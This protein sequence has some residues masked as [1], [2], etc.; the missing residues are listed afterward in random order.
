M[1]EPFMATKIDGRVKAQL[2]TEA[3][4]RASA[5]AAVLGRTSAFT[6]LKVPAV[7]DMEAV[8]AATTLPT[9]LL[10]GEVRKDQDAYFESWRTALAVPNLVGVVVGRSQLYPSDDDVALAV[11]TAVGLFPSAPVLS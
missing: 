10:G 8:A 2:R 9:L 4:V 3:A 7:D 11:D 6:W 1:V 5:I